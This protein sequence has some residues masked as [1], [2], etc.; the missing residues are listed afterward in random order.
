MSVDELK[1]LMEDIKWRAAGQSSEETNDIM[2]FIET[3]LRE[4]SQ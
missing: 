3:R 1:R 4:I 2:K